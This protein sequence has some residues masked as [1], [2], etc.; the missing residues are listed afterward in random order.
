MNRRAFGQ[1]VLR[2]K[3]TVRGLSH[4]EPS[5]AL[6][7]RL[8]HVTPH[9][10]RSGLLDTVA[11]SASRAECCRHPKTM[12][13]L[14]SPLIRSSK[15]RPY[16]TEADGKSSEDDEDEG[17][18]RQ[19]EKLDCQIGKGTSNTIVMS[20]AE[21]ESRVSLIRVQEAER[22]RQEMIDGA[23]SGL[24]GAVFGSV[25]FGLFFVW[26][27]MDR[28][29]RDSDGKVITTLNP[30]SYF[31]CRYFL[32]GQK[33]LVESARAKI[34]K[35]MERERRRKEDAE[36]ARECR[37]RR[38]PCPHDGYEMVQKPT[39]ASPPITKPDWDRLQKNVECLLA[40]ELERNKAEHAEEARLSRLE[41]LVWAS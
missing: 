24:R 14:Q 21:F 4:C 16:M 8:F 29:V 20:K 28:T 36:E 23:T 13:L 37:K 1:S 31:R 34:A 25:I 6:S 32:E 38:S 5:K 11:S 39:A 27:V 18:K 26:A 17:P 19:S 35:E 30:F 22:V 7:T 9:L 12:S 40:A 10:T 2:I 3:P 33:S 41:R 15:F